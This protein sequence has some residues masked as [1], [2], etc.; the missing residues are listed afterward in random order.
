MEK[1]SGKEAKI[2]NQINSMA[3]TRMTKNV[4]TVYFNGHLV[5]SIRVNILTICDKGMGRCIGQIKV[6]IKVNGIRVYNVDMVSSIFLKK[7]SEKDIF[8]IMYTKVRN[9]KTTAT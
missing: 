3:S 7:D 2:L 5:I 9:L 6:I 8:L 4:V 1:E